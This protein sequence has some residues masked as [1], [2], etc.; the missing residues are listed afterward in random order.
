MIGSSRRAAGEK[1]Q[2]VP[3]AK[4]QYDAAPLARDAA[5]FAALPPLNVLA[6]AAAIYPDKVAVIEG[7]RRFT[8][9]EFGAR[10][11]RFADALRRRGIAPGDTVAGLAPHVPAL[12]E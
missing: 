3:A 2:A 6:R 11:R 12:L 10:C 7:A 5:N 8:Y 9:G 4:G 1:G